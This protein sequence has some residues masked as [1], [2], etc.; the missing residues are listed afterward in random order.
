MPLLLLFSSP[1]SAILSG[2]GCNIYSPANL[3]HRKFDLIS[4]Y[5]YQ[6]MPI[7]QTQQISNFKLLHRLFVFCNS[8]ETPFIISDL[9]FRIVNGP[10]LQLSPNSISPS[11]KLCWR[12]MDHLHKTFLILLALGGTNSLE[13]NQPNIQKIVPDLSFYRTTI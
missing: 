4:S 6:K 5:N 10:A 11:R 7:S 13:T 2:S 1:L 12:K 8:R 9:M 3:I